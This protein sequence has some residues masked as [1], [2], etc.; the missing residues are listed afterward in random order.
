M[1]KMFLKLLKDEVVFLAI[2]VAC[3]TFDDVLGLI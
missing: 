3:G 1:M 2:F